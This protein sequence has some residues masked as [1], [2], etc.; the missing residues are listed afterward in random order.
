MF[1]VYLK[2]IFPYSVIMRMTVTGEVVAIIPGSRRLMTGEVVTV[3]PVP[4]VGQE[5]LVVVT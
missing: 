5:V 2:N 4:V 1:K 3:D